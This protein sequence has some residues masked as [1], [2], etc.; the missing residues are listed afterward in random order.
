MKSPE[1]MSRARARVEPTISADQHAAAGEAGAAH[2]F[3]R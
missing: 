3:D 1:T 2:Y